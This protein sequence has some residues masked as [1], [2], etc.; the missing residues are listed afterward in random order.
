MRHASLILAASAALAPVAALHTAASGGISQHCECLN[1]KATYAS[2]IVQCGKGKE[3]Y[4][5]SPLKAPTMYRSDV[6]AVQKKICDNFYTRLEF[7]SCVSMNPGTEEGTWCY[8]D[9]QCKQLIGGQELANVSWKQCGKSDTY[10]H[11]RK[12][13]QVRDSLLSDYT[14]EE[15]LAL[16]Q[17]DDLWFGGLARMAYRGARAGEKKTVSLAEFGTQVP[18]WLFEHLGK[19]GLRATP[20]WLDTNEDGSLPFVLVVN[21]KV[22]KV[23]KRPDRQED[24]PGT[25]AGLECMVN[26]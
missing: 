22:Y 4:D 21:T 1:W 2:G 20:Y 19:E 18:P 3:F 15:L 11:Y 24:H 14:P 25:W 6:P 13:S 12:T 10:G 8:V 17:K 23:D 9:K 26:C 7:S 5:T 16:S